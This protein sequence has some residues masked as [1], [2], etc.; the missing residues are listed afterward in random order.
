MTEPMSRHV[1]R[2]NTMLILECPFCG[3]SDVYVGSDDGTTYQATCVACYAT[4]SLSTKLDAIDAWNA[5]SE[6]C[7][8]LG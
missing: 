5:V 7:R 3:S 8:P 2:D 4:G 1:Y 6:D